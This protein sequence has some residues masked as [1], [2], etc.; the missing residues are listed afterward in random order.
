MVPPHTSAPPSRCCHGA[1]LPRQG[2]G[3]GGFVE[4]DAGEVAAY[5]ADHYRDW[6]PKALAVYSPTAPLPE[7][8]TALVAQLLLAAAD[9]ADAKGAAAAAGAATAAPTQQAGGGRG[10]SGGGAR[11]RGTGGVADT[12]LAAAAA[13]AAA[14]FPC[15]AARR[16]AE[17]ARAHPGFGGL[18]V[19]VREAFAAAERAIARHEAAAAK[20]A[21]E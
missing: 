19:G 12:G 7:G 14:A 21:A 1:P 2:K 6:A 16:L 18:A 8:A 20:A 10:R 15:A 5:L 11:G 3:S 13:A 17:A 4:G 9:D